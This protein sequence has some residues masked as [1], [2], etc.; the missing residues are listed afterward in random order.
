MYNRNS[1]TEE[2]KKKIG[3]ANKGKH[4]NA[5]K[6][7]VIFDGVNKYCAKCKEWK[8]V[9]EFGKRFDRPLG[10]RSKCKVCD[11]IIRMQDKRSFRLTQY[12]HGA[13]RRGISFDLTVEEFNTLWQLP[14]N[15]CGSEIQEIGID[16]VDS[17]Q[18]YRIDNVV[19]CCAICNTMKLALPRSIFVEHCQKVANHYQETND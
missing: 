19:P 14:C 16:R 7:K 4:L 3:I 1:K 13:K 2:H 11:N 15:Y 17:T 6:G 9:D 10:L 5:S 18:G 12:R 8:T